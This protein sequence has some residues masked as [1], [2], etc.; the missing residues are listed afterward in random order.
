G[1]PA[2]EPSL[3][4]ERVATLQLCYQELVALAGERRRCLEA[5]RLLCKFLWDAGEEEAW[6]REQE[7]L[8]RSEELGRDLSSSSRL[9]SRHD[10]VRGE[11]S[12]RQGPMQQLLAQGRELLAQGNEDS[13]AASVR[14][15]LQ[16]LQERW[17]S[18]ELLAEQREA[19][20]QEATS[21]FQLQADSS[22][23]E[24]WLEEAWLLVSS[25]ELGHDEFSARSLLRQ[26]R[27][28]QEDVRSRRAALALLQQQAQA[29][30]Q[31]L[32]AQLWERAE[33]R[34][35]QLQG[36]LS[37]YTMSSEA[38][39]C[40]LWLAEKEQWLHAMKVPDSLED[41]EV[42]Q[43]RWDRFRSLAEQKKETLASALAMQNFQLEC[44]ETSSWMQE[45]AKVLASSSSLPQELPGLLSMQRK[46]SAVARDL[47]AIE[48][49][50]AELRAEGDK[51]VAQ[52][53]AQAAAIA[54]RL[55]AIEQLLQELCQSLRQRE[56]A[57]G[58][59]SRLQE[60]LRELGALQ[61]WLSRT[62]LAV[63]SQQLPCSPGEAEE[64][65]RQHESLAK[66]MCHYTADYCSARARGQQLLQGSSPGHAELQHRLQ[67]LHSSWE[68]LG[69]SWEKRQQLLRQALAFQLFL[70]DAKQEHSLSQT[71]LPCS[72]A[73]AAG[74][75]RKH[76]ELEATMEATGQR[77]QALGTS[78]HKLLAEDNLHGHKVQELLQSLQSSCSRAGQVTA[79]QVTAVQVTAGCAVPLQLGLW[80]EEKLQR[81][82]DMSCGEA[83]ELHCKWQKHQA[84]AAE[85]AANRGW[86]QDMHK[87][88]ERLCKST[89]ELQEVVQQQLQWLQNSW[90]QLEGASSTKAQRLFG[91]VQA[92]LCM[93]ACS[94]LR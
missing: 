54:A 75:L 84:F 19:R 14:Q 50:V 24:S 65:L 39:A 36:A 12:A 52:E 49:K 6:M 69:S 78:G 60:C 23:A 9:L 86:L 74:A 47:E 55:Q 5:S 82:Q 90:Q 37:F 73:A 79:V 64:L 85:L 51:L 81:A 20:L 46:L 21:S 32:H 88:G 72:L 41:L 70:R 35:Q 30:P 48:A 26:H 68:E 15:R 44:T 94:S 25:P 29:L 27:E 38:D 58:E 91:A 43:Q 45:K 33:Q 10:A 40:G 7:R 18:L 2:C 42:V 28:L 57:L 53:P 77:L 71:E 13:V 87:E 76:E 67:G 17:S 16:E 83:R 92:Q 66:E 59:A 34:Q 93:Q 3:V 11:L 56:A 1:S 80:L 31:A 22:D 63:S 8:L 4:Q 62:L 61:G 89:P